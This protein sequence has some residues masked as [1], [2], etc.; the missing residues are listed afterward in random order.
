MKEREEEVAEEATSVSLICIHINKCL[1]F[2]C[3]ASKQKQR[4]REETLLLQCVKCNTCN[5]HSNK[6]EN[7]VFCIM[8]VAYITHYI[9]NIMTNLRSSEI[10]TA[11][12]L[13]HSPLHK[14]IVLIYGKLRLFGLCPIKKRLM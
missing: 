7:K 12:D 4:E 5:K 9:P 8:G 3:T 1:V 6:V 13:C 2:V 10:I 14:L 11:V